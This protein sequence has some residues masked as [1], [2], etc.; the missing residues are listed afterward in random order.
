MY[1]VDVFIT[2]V[3]MFPWLYAV[4]GDTQRACFDLSVF[5]EGSHCAVVFFLNNTSDNFC[6]I[7][8]TV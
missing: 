1:P 5:S 2:A 8:F 4:S 6:C 7:L 3:L